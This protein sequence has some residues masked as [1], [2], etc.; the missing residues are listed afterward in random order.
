MDLA[1]CEVFSLCIL[2]C[3]L[4]RSL[5]SFGPCNQKQNRSMCSSETMKHIAHE[6]SLLHLSRSSTS[7]MC[8][9]LSVIGWWQPY[10]TRQSPWFLHAALTSRL[11]CAT[12]IIIQGMKL[13]TLIDLYWADTNHLLQ[14]SISAPCSPFRGICHLEEHSE[15]EL[16]MSMLIYD[17]RPS[18]SKGWNHT[19]R[20]YYV[21]G[22]L[23]LSQILSAAP[24]VI[25]PSELAK[26]QPACISAPSDTN[27]LPTIG[28]KGGNDMW[29]FI[30]TPK[31]PCASIY[32]SEQYHLSRCIIESSM[33]LR[34]AW[35]P[36]ASV[37]AYISN[38]VIVES[39]VLSRAVGEA[40]FNVTACSIMCRKGRD[41]Y[42]EPCIEL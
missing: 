17:G 12:Q 7:K 38:F 13:N 6:Q 1:Y 24:S 35:N 34:K 39:Q 25:Q 32:I 16:R 21:K 8:I 41:S 30:S 31:T 26:P 11:T 22:Q 2:L 19:F 29:G 9:P 28:L 4:L 14:G 20:L 40:R 5:P 42:Q 33:L 37:F 27:I 3:K 23:P 18:F 10:F 36:S 15:V